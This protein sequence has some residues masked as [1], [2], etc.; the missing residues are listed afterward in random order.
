MKKKV[1]IKIF[2]REYEL[3]YKLDYREESEVYV[4]TVVDYVNKKYDEISS[5]SKLQSL[6]DIALL[7]SMDLADELMDER[8]KNGELKSI[9]EEGI[10]NLQKIKKGSLSCS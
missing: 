10:S 9:I 4:K 1:K 3:D 5:F 6:P 2:D 8:K 7:V